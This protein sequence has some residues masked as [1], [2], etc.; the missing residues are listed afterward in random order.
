MSLTLLHSQQQSL[1]VMCDSELD[2]MRWV[3]AVRWICKSEK[4][5][6]INTKMWKLSRPVHIVNNISSSGS[7]SSTSNGNG[8]GHNANGDDK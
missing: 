1:D 3:R 8:N 7:S 2:L 6:E 5:R 4:Q